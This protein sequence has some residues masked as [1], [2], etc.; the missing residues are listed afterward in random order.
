MWC[1]VVYCCVCRYVLCW[2]WCWCAMCG[3]WCAWCVRGVCCVVV[4]SVCS[5]AWHAENPPCVGSKRLRVK[6]QNASVC[7]GKTRACSTHVRVLPLH[8]LPSFSSSVLFP[9]FSF[10]ALFSRLLPFLSNNDNDHSSNRLSL[11]AHGSDLP[12][13]QSAWAKAHSL[14]AEHVRRMQETTVL[15]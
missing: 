12:E 1:V 9:S 7:T 4:L 15:A 3:V 14:L 11:C 10:S 5:A 2:C 8:S 13:C 6:V